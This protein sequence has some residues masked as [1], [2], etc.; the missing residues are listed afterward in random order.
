M[1]VD[2]DFEDTG[3]TTSILTKKKKFSSSLALIS[4]KED[5]LNLFDNE[6]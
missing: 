2:D 3:I 1:E 6:K 4:T 5:S